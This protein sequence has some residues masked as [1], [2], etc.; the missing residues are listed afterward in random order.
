VGGDS[1]DLYAIPKEKYYV[2]IC[3]TNLFREKILRKKSK[4]IEHSLIP[5]T[6]SNIIRNTIKFD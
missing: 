1:T 4:K 2:L 3:T 6:L 5:V